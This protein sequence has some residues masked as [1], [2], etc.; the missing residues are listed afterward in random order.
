MMKSALEW[1]GCE[2]V[3]KFN[4]LTD[5]WIPVERV[6]G[7][8]EML[9]IADTLA[10]A[11]ELHGIVCRSPLET[12]AVKRLLTAFLMDALKPQER[13]ELKALFRA[14]H[15]P[16]DR[17]NDY[18][19]LCEAEGASFDLFDEKRPFMQAAYDEA[20]DKEKKKP[21]AVL[22]HEF[23][24]GNNHVHFDHRLQTEHRLTYAE[25][26][27]ALCASYV[28]C[29]SGLS[30][31]SSVNNTPC[32]YIL[33][34][35]DNLF[36]TLVLGMVS[37]S[38]CGKIPMDDLPVAWR[39]DKKIVPAEQCADMSVLAAFTWMPRR[40][41]LI[42]DAEEGYVKEVYIQPGLNFL[43]N[44]RWMDPHVAYRK[45]K[46]EEWYSVK[47]QS[48]R[49]F[50]RD[51]GMIAAAYQENASHIPPLAVAHY[52]KITNRQESLVRLNMT[53]L[54]T[55]QAQY[56]SLQC[57][58]LSLPPAIL[59]IPEK[60]EFLREKMML[61]ESI[62]GCVESSYG[63]LEASAARQLL[64][65]YFSSI[66]DALFSEFLPLLGKSDSEQENWQ[67]PLIS[68][69]ENRILDTLKKVSDEAAGMFGAGAKN[70]IKLT[71]ATD[72]CMGK[73][74][75]ILKK[76]RGEEVYAD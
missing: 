64:A 26:L 15:F 67:M 8:Q 53:G 40:V 9:G 69:L 38:E 56:L 24:S 48:G 58:T 63:K 16:V 4:V 54:V 30:G 5:P 33:C 25:A 17:I 72:V 12:Y 14:E 55:N 50:W 2:S 7:S 60:G 57:E 32:T 68:L 75:S 18:I 37:K 76:S 65:L 39:S 42:P 10:H 19:A 11:H 61:I 73:S 49:E 34:D 52:E 62:A 74:W 21:V 22:V 70:L 51:I 13:A 35:E 31:P 47:P 27:R 41:T 23:P 43:G 29:T 66:R 28:F 3:A 6:D 44:G 45:N 46:K 36:R 71:K 59:E 1:K 20:L